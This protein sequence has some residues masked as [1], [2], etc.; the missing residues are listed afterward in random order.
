MNSIINFEIAQLKSLQNKPTIYY[1]G[2]LELLKKPK[3]SIVGTRKPFNYTQLLTHQL[4]QKLSLVGNCIVSGGAMGV[5]AIAHKAAGVENTI[6]VSP[7]GIN[8]KYPAINKKL[9]TQIEQEGLLL[10]P[11]DEDFK[12]TNYSFV[13]RN[14][15]VVALG[16]ILIVSQADLNSGSLRS[17]EYAKKMGKDIYVLPHRINESLGTNELIKEGSAKVIY[18][19]DEFTKEFTKTALQ[20]ENSNN[21]LEFCKTNPTFDEALLKYN[22]LVYEY[23]LEGKIK[24]KNGFINLC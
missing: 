16:D 4:A 7:C 2:N 15:I 13:Q 20:K 1:K 3:I 21:F 14:E 11:F 22:S 19:I 12:A 9:I 24:I 10:S 6:L 23:E 5:D 8:Y 17:V 18:D